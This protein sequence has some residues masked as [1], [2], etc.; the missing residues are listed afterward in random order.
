VSI[1]LSSSL[2]SDDEQN[3]SSEISD[4]SLRIEEPSDQSNPEI[5]TNNLSG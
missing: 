2:E 3:T 4:I 5:K 1:N